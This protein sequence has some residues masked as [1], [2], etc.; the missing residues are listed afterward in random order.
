M[1]NFKIWISN[2]STIYFLI[3]SF[4]YVLNVHSQDKKEK[5]IDS[6]KVDNTIAISNIPEETEKVAQLILKLEKV[7]K[8]STEVAVVDSLINILSDGIDEKKDSIF[9]L[10][11]NV[12]RR[13]IQELKVDW[14]DHKS[15][16]S[17][18]QNQLKNRTEEIGQISDDLIVEINKWELT[19]K[20]FETADT[21][22]KGFEGI[23]NVIETL[24][25]VMSTSHA[26]LDKVF[27]IQHRLTQLVLH[28]D[29][30]IEEIRVTEA[31]MKKEYFVFDSEPIWKKDTTNIISTNLVELQE[32]E[33]PKKNKF[34]SS[35]NKLL[36]FIS[37]HLKTFIFQILFIILF[38]LIIIKANKNW[39]KELNESSTALEIQTKV[40]LSH[41]ISATL[42]A[43]VLISYFFYSAVIST[44]AEVLMLLILLGTVYLLPRLTHKRFT[45]PLLLLFLAFIINT[46]IEFVE[47]ST[48]QIRWVLILNLVII[49]IAL[50]L[51]RKIATTY[52]EKFRPGFRFFKIITPIYTLISIGGIIGNIIGM[53]SLSGFITRGVLL[54]TLLGVVVF[55]VVRVITSLVIVLF[56]FRKTPNI[57][58]LSTLID[59]SNRRIQPALNWFGVFLW[60]KFTLSA[61]EMY[62]SFL[63]WVDEIMQVEW[64]IGETTISL[65]GVLAFTSIIVITLILA[66]LMATL[67]QDEW[68]IKM[69]P[70]GA[71]SAMSLMLRILIICVGFYL[72]LSAIGSDL[73]KLSLI[74]GALGVGIGFGLQSV[75]SN[76]I[77]GLILAFER[78]I[79][80]GDAIEVDQEMGVVT[81]IGVRSSNI[82]TYSGAEA[83]IPN[84][85]LISKKV[86]NWTLSDR[87]RRSKV[88]MKTDPKA[89]PEKII[90]LFNSIATSH[91][92]TFNNPAPKTYFYGYDENGNLSFALLYWSTF[93]NTLKTNHEIALQIFED[94]KKEGLQAPAPIRRIVNS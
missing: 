4:F 43:G 15:E 25:E 85:D 37:S 35:K 40:I 89:E 16:L 83:I 48:N 52:P 54:S 7:L 55:I 93:S 20:S 75:V 1:K 91:E 76:F 47:L 60:V 14:G 33:T 61:F 71:S 11:K 29:E 5:A 66:K 53:V 64:S 27:N 78:P 57:Q 34:K 8:P 68:M 74:I 9:S 59:I 44:Y 49:T 17:K 73:S 58:T 50:V 28:I 3:L 72:A 26:Q 19:R 94:L 51:A 69:L 6:I 88:L 65:G 13:G 12:S 18:Y 77:S 2:K 46:Y 92:N 42:V 10:L 36:D 24:Q 90:E 21:K 67:F 84:G 80:I 31:Q 70:R 38:F 30:L 81:N 56:N 41:P 32:N 79:N 23:D 87:D 22:K 82:R 39:N 62:G 63:I 45:T 86:V